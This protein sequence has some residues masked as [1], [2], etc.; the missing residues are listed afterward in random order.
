M[1]NQTLK[2]VLIQVPEIKNVSQKRQRKLQVTE[3]NEVRTNLKLIKHQTGIT[4]R[5]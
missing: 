4:D 2:C 5:K 3:Y 1:S